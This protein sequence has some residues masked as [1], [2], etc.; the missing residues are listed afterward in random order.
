LYLFLLSAWLKWEVGNISIHVNFWI[1]FSLPI[2][3]IFMIY[4][5]KG[6]LWWPFWLFLINFCGLLCLML[7]F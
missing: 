1:N 7:S 3:C 6:W 2:N 4:S 5:Y